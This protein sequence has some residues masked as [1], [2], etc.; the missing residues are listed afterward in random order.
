LLPAAL[1]GDGKTDLINDGG[2]FLGNGD[3]TFKWVSQLGSDS[4]FTQQF[5]DALADIDGDGKPDVIGRRYSG[6]SHSEGVYP[7][8]GDGIFGFF[9]DADDFG[10][11]RLRWVRV[12]D[13]NGDG[14]PDLIFFVD[15]EAKNVCAAKYEC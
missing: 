9:I 2:V 12:A 6:S 14:K 1:N 5:A 3:G 13:M 8:Y 7:G 4:P 10:T 15:P 11:S